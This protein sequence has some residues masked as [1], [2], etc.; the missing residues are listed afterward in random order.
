RFTLPRPART[1]RTGSTEMAV[2]VRALRPT[3]AAVS[4]L[5]PCSSAFPEGIAGRPLAAIAP[6][7]VRTFLDACRHRDR[8][9]CPATA[10]YDSP[11]WSRP[12]RHR[13]NCD[14]R[15]LTPGPRPRRPPHRRPHN[16]RHTARP[17]P[18]PARLRPPPPARSRR[19]EPAVR[20]T[21]RPDRPQW[22]RQVIPA[23]RP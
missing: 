11:A 23:A 13:P 15:P 14:N 20:R 17:D 7:G 3:L 4:S 5:W 6:D 19:P 18:G 21:H 10:L 1:N 22:R 16:V 12:A 9:I 2:P 8:P